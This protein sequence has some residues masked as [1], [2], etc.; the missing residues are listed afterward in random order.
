HDYLM[1]ERA[2]MIDLMAWNADATRMPYRMHTEYL[3]RLFLHNDLAEGRFDAGGRPVALSDIR[4]P[5]FCVATTR[6]HVAP[7]RSVYRIHLLADTEVTFLLTSGGHNA[8]IVSE[9]G[10]RGR[11]YRVLTKAPADRYSDPE[12]WQAAATAKDGSWW[13]EWIEWLGARSGRPVDPPSMG[14]GGY[15]PLEDAPGSYV[16]QA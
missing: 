2:G 12:A 1:G 15:E 5:I 13:P 10:R 16:L 14:R 8:G 9:P 6:D 3:R 4:T 11:S 7:W